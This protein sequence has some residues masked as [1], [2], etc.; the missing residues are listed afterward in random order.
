MD[1]SRGGSRES[2]GRR[3]LSFSGGWSCSIST[4]KASEEGCGAGGLPLRWPSSFLQT[5]VAEEKRPTLQRDSMRARVSSGLSGRVWSRGGR[6]RIEDCQEEAMLKIFWEILPPAVIPARSCAGLSTWPLDREL[7]STKPGSSWNAATP[8][9]AITAFCDTAWTRRYLEIMRKGSR[10][11]C[12]IEYSPALKVAISCARS[13]SKAGGAMSA[14]GATS[15]AIPAAIAATACAQRAASLAAVALARA[16]VV[17]STREELARY[18]K[19]NL[20]YH[21]QVAAQGREEE[22]HSGWSAQE[23]HL[24]E[25]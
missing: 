20:A 13:M 18:W 14:G 22:G 16:R 24:E 15:W 17:L 23:G 4:A 12:K 19:R 21:E 3:S 9:A 11:C 8:L 10:K 7:Y 6:A 5:R 25:V 1:V 2:S